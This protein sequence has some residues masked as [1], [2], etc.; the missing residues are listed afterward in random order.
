MP[1][2]T[3][4]VPISDLHSG[5]TTALFPN[6]FVQF[7]HANRKPTR[8]QKAMFKH[9]SFCA[10]KV[11]E[12]RKGKKL[13]IVHDGDAIEGFHH[14]S[15]QVITMLENEQIDIHVE[16]MRHFKKVVGFSGNDEIHYLAAT[17]VHTG[18]NEEECGRQ[19]GATQNDLGFYS[20]DELR[21]SINGKMLWFSHHGPTAGKGANAGNAQRNFLR[22][23]FYDCIKHGV[24]VPDFI[25]TAHTHIPFY[26]TYIQKH[27]GKYYVVRGL[28]CPS[29]Q[30]KT[31]F[32][33]KVAPLSV[34]EIGLQYF[35]VSKDGMIS[36]PVEWIMR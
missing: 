18:G 35:T 25:T 33:H 12:A 32:A 8:E 7:K 13:I 23:L 36:D 16:L 21:L 19:V 20:S 34:N 15:H 4:V 10:D 6:H 5:G 3:L 24:T 29:W 22:D 27:N 31:R 11:A 9:W 14:N 30:Q 1:N 17:E 28:I 26:N 2:D